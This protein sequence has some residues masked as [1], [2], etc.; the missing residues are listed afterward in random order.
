MRWR[1]RRLTI[2]F[3]RL[4][5]SRAKQFL[6]TNGLEDGGHMAAAMAL[7]ESPAIIFAISMANLYRT[8]EGRQEHQGF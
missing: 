6:E 1:F 4:L 3:L 7:M 2:L 5:S 8:Q